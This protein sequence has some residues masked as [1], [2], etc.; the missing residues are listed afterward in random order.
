MIKRTIGISLLCFIIA[1]SLF[2]QSSQDNIIS[3]SGTAD[4]YVIPDEAVI[5]MGIKVWDEDI[6]EAKN[7]FY[8]NSRELTNL[9]ETYNIDDKY[10]K[11]DMLSIEPTYKKFS[12]Q[13][14]EGDIVNGYRFFK[15]VS[16]TVKDIG[17]VEELL[18]K[19]IY[20]G[21]TNLYGVDYRTSEFRENMDKARIEA[22]KAAK[23][24]AEMLASELGQSIGKAIRIKEPSYPGSPFGR[25]ANVMHMSGLGDSGPDIKPGM[26][27]VSASVNVDFQLK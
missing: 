7:K 6:D 3:V 20:S 27:K 18:T 12:K 4:I 23:E 1:S 5:N 25:T 8:E 9:L 21:A 26:I 22:I 2:A 24:K 13:A 17:K 10:I 16:V 19:I 14:Y 11:T 15:R